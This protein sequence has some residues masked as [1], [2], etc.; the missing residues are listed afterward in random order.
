MEP[1]FKETLNFFSQSGVYY[2]T[3]KRVPYKKAGL[4]AVLAETTVNADDNGVENVMGP[5]SIR[6]LY[7]FL[8]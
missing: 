7:V 4:L 6:R 2:N 5:R 1:S 8:I 3:L